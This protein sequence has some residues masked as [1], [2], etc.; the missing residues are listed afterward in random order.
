MF[1]AHWATCADK[2]LRNTLD[3]IDSIARYYYTVT[4]S[5]MIHFTTILDKTILESF[6]RMFSQSVQGSFL[7]LFKS[8]ASKTQLLVFD[9]LES[10]F[11]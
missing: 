1:I 5:S 9:I 3:F 2:E 4:I 10:M 7:F 6:D 11:Q 8:P